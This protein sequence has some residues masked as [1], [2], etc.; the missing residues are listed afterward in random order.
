MSND[1]SFTIEMPLSYITTL[2]VVI[3]NWQGDSK[4]TQIEMDLSTPKY[5]TNQG[6]SLSLDFTNKDDWKNKE[7]N[8]FVGLFN[9][10]N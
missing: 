5:L 4:V 10:V 2:E 6:F 1:G 9:L 3:S 8:Y 7:T